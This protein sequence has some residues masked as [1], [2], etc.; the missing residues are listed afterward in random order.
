MKK[1]DALSKLMS[2][3]HADPHLRAEL[4]RHPEAVAEQR[5]IELG[6]E[7]IARL[8][9]L[10]ASPNWW[11]MSKTVACPAAATRGSAIR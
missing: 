5:G 2:E 10:A 8:K 1:I 11:P 3:A 4:L 6:E 9:K 7:E